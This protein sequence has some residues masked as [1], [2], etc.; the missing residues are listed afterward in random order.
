MKK[1]L[2][3]IAEKRKY[4]LIHSNGEEIAGW[5]WS[6][7]Y[8]VTFPV[9]EKL[10]PWQKRGLMYSTGYGRKIP[11]SRQ[12][13]ILNRWRRIYCCNFSNSGTCYVIVQG[14]DVIVDDC[15]IAPQ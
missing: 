12:L 3:T 6:A 13:Y 15:N 5:Y 1:L 8:D 14:Q 4:S 2:E 9:R 10:L 7:R 11:T